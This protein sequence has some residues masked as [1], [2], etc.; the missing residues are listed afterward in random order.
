MAEQPTSR[1][2]LWYV[3][4]EGVVLGPLG[5]ARVR[6][7]LLQ[8]SLDLDDEISP[9]GERW[10]PLEAVAEVM[11]LELRAL[12]GDR[13]AQQRLHSRR[14][15]AQL[16]RVGE[17]RGFPW[18]S[19]LVLLLGLSSILGLALWVGR[20]DGL[21]GPDC[22]ARPA[23]GVNWRQCRLPGV[24]V[25]SASLVGANLNSA[26][27]RQG[28]FMGVDLSA[29]DLRY[30]DLRQADLSYSLLVGSRLLGADLRRAS[31]VS[32]DLRRADLRFADLRGASLGG[33]DL[34]AA[35]LAR[36]IWVDGR[37]CGE[38]SLGRCR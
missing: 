20:P 6:H 12:Q 1:E 2:G 26:L 21:D 30:A 15:M 22:Q 8:S 37:T 4:H 33:A 34:G 16:Q 18:R 10:Q 38:G 14:L 29:A 28:R 31:L 9:D 24:D 11:P 7:L 25:G 13:A 36:A 23:P 5:S 3:R 19:A 35:R 17:G 27:L 32:A